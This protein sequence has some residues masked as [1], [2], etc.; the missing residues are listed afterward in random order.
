MTSKNP[1]PVDRYWAALDAALPGFTP[2]EQ[3]VAVTLY[4]ELAKGQPV[5]AAELGPALGRSAS[6]VRALLERDSLKAF[7]Y[8]DD[9]GR[10][11]G[12]G[13][14][15]TTRMRHHLELEGRT[16]WT[17][18]AWD[19][20]F[21][22]EILGERAR[23]TSPDPETGEAIRLT[24]TPQAIESAEPRHVVMSFLLPDHELV[25]AANLVKTFC[26]FIFFFG[27]R[28]SGERWVAQHPGTFLYSLDDAF[29]LAKRFTAR[30][31]GH[32]LGRR[33]ATAA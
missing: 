30:K 4:R 11:S 10:V 20:L 31:F 8:L 26:H 25:S 12:F 17:W 3:Q 29:A 16:L 27:S 7:A 32:E 14:L 23:V 15:A 22:P 19:T 6:E 13:G 18:C 5:D 28:A 2:E 9:R 33:R 24:V 21:V 1:P